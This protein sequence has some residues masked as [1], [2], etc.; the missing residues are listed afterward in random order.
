MLRNTVR[1]AVGMRPLGSALAPRGAEKADWSRADRVLKS[2]QT[3]TKLGSGIDLYHDAT[4]PHFFLADHGGGR[5]RLCI[6]QFD[7]TYLSLVR[8]LEDVERLRSAPQSD[9][10]LSFRADATRP[11]AAYLRLNLVG[12]ERQDDLHE[13]L[14]IE[15]G[16]RSV[17]F[18]L[19]AL[20]IE[21]FDLR[22]V[23]ADIILSRP[24]M[25]ETWISD[26]SL[27]VERAAQ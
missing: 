14:V 26:I 13:A 8:S 25:S 9:V 17:R 2:P 22:S 11:L 12:A 3:G 19:S 4:S 1:R 24:G 6:Y 20:D 21:T 7:G 27:G 18:D 23:W 10:F 16:H 5:F 15:S